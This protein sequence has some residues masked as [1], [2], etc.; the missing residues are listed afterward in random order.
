MIYFM[1]YKVNQSLLMVDTIRER[2]YEHVIKKI[3]IDWK[4]KASTNKN[5]KKQ[6]AYKAFLSK[7]IEIYLKHKKL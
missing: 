5:E 4:F 7:S 6:N 2:V 3:I 1:S